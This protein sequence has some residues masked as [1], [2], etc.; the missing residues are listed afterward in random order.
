MISVAMAAYNGMPYIIQQVNSILSELSDDDELVVSDNG[1][2]DGTWA[3]LLQQAAINSRIRPLLYTEKQG[4]VA[5]I[6]NALKLCHGELIFLSDQDDIWLSGRVQTMSRP[7]ED[8]PD[9]LLVQA[10]A[11]IVDNNGQIIE[12]SFFAWRNCGSGILKNYLKNTW[13]GCSLCCRR[14]LVEI[15]LPFPQYLPM[16]DMWLGIIAEMYGDVQFLPDILLQHRRHNQN[17][18]A[19]SRSNMFQVMLWRIQLANALLMKMLQRRHKTR[20]TKKNNN[21]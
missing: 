11:Q 17:N 5:N 20:L 14:R 6:A 12:Q 16:H 13:Q 21:R 2:S 3:W 10:D 15:A 8:N 19:M 4:I 18:S 1:S 9:L 7:F